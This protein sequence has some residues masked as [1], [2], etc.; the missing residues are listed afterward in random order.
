MR[1]RIARCS[2]G[3][4]RP[5]TVKKNTWYETPVRSP[6]GP[7]PLHRSLRG[8]GLLAGRS[9]KSTCAVLLPL[10]VADLLAKKIPPGR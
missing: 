5:N 10:T 4:I 9:A 1:P 2:P 8:Y 3:R 7:D 6:G